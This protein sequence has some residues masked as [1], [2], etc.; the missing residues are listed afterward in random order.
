MTKIVNT[1]DILEKMNNFSSQKDAEKFIKKYKKLP[2]I[3]A[4][5]VNYAE[6]LIAKNHYDTAILIYLE[7][8]QNKYLKDL[9]DEIYVWFRL[10][11][12]YINNN[13]IE[14]GKEYLIKLCDNYENYE[15]SFEFRDL[16]FDWKRIKAYVED[17][18]KPSISFNNTT[19]NNTPMTD[20][21]LLELFIEEMAS[22]GIHAYLTNYGHRLESTLAAAQKADKPITAELLKLLKNKY[23]NGKMPENIETIE[24]T[25][26]KNDWWF[27]EEYDEY[28]CK[29]EQELG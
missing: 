1:D 22:G 15:E 3:E 27:E 9:I 6:E 29:I 19:Q 10:G 25:I 14:K 11:E 21:E 23:F 24:N 16:T 17:D 7:L 8:V 2:F 5:M 13:D 20:N 12:Y 4:I 28:Y 18:I 26:L